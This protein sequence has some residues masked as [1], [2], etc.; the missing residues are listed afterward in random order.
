MLPGSSAAARH[1]L[2]PSRPPFPHLWLRPPGLRQTRSPLQNVDR[3]A[4]ARVA[5]VGPQISHVPR[6]AG[7]LPCLLGPTASSSKRCPTFTAEGV[8]WVNRES[9]AGQAR[10][11]RAPHLARNLLPG[12]ASVPQLEQTTTRLPEL[13]DSPRMVR[14]T[15]RLDISIGGERNSTA[16]P[17]RGQPLGFSGPRSRSRSVLGPKP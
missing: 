3:G 9:Q 8:G 10:V 17:D 15:R 14:T 16:A 6:L 4:R 13:P 11:T 2:L 5:P 12:I 1:S 7:A